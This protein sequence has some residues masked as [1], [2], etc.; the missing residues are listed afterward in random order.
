[1]NSSSVSDPPIVLAKNLSKRFGDFL[2]VDDINLS[3]PTGGCFGLLGPNGA[4]KTTTLRMFLGQSHQS[5]GSLHVLGQV[6]PEQTRSVRRKIGV[7]PQLDNLDVDFT[8]IENLK[9]YASFFA[10]NFRDIESYIDELLVMVELEDKRN[11]RISELSGGMKRRL[12]IARALVNKPKLLVLDEPTTGLD[13]QVRHLIWSRLREL[14]NSGTT[15]LLT[16]HYME[17]AERLCDDLV[18]MDKG[19]ILKRGH[20]KQLISEYVE[21]DVIEIHCSMEM[22]NSLLKQV[23]D[24]RYELVDETVYCFTNEPL[25]II[26]E[27]ET[28]AGLTWLH[29]PANLEDVFLSLTGRE[30]HEAQ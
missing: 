7:V 10:L 26:K 6:M 30:L 16:T 28:Q 4:G 29:R 13:P 20:P 14:K 11:T 18:I 5:S 21:S 19:K 9:V 1:M 15:L 8:V 17:E 25:K 3:V 27:L 24:I 2:A 23:S 22:A 12:S